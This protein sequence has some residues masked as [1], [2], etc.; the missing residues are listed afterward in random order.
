MELPTVAVPLPLVTLEP[1]NLNGWLSPSPIV[2][3][4]LAPILEPV[5]QQVPNINLQVISTSLALNLLGTINTPI[6][7][8]STGEFHILASSKDYHKLSTDIVTNLGEWLP[9]SK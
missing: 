6:M 1:P 4:Q 8:S 9:P 3:K 7:E 2:E 5:T